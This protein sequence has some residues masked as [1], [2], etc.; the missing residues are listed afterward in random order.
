[1][2]ISKKNVALL[3][4]SVAML[5]VLLAVGM[6][7][8][9]LSWTANAQYGPPPPPPPGD[10]GGGAGAA[11]PVDNPSFV[12]SVICGGGVIAVLNANGTI[13]VVAPTGLIATLN[14][15]TFAP[16][17]PSGQAVTTAGPGASGNY[18]VT[19]Y[20]LG[21]SPTNGANVYQLN[22]YV[23]GVL[24]CDRPLVFVFA[25]A[26]GIQARIGA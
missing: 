22:V 15:A 17:N 21:V 5:A 26:V 7:F 16:T 18:T 9:G 12:G 6:P 4:G 24:L 19:V 2:R 11:A 23:N 25:N 10:G 13:D 14:P 20:Y 1:M 8:S 3:L